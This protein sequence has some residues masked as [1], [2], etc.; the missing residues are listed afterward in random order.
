M[1]GSIPDI[2][3]GRN[4][5]PKLPR[6]ATVVLCLGLVPLMLPL[7][8]GLGATD[9]RTD[10]AIYAYAV[11]SMLES[12]DWSTPRASLTDR[13]YLSKPPL[14]FW[15]VAAGVR[16]GLIAHDERGMRTFDAVFA[17]LAFVY[18]F[19]LGARLIDP[20]AGLA[21]V[22]LLSIQPSLM[23]QH[24]LRAGGMESMLVLQFTA[25][26]YHL[27]AWARWP[28]SAWRSVHILA[29][30]AWLAFGTLGK[31][32][33]L[34][35]PV[36]LAPMV[37]LVADWRRRLW[38]DRWRWCAG[39]A[40]AAALIAPWFILQTVRHGESFWQH[41]V[42]LL[43]VRRFT[44]GLATSHVAPWHAYG[45]WLYQDLA[46][47]RALPWVTFGAGLW[48]FRVVRRRWAEGAVVLAWIVLPLL[49]LSKSTSKLHHY[50]Y[51]SLPAAAL[52]GG[53][54]LSLLAAV[55]AAL[56]RWLASGSQFAPWVE[57]RGYVA[58]AGLLLLTVWPLGEVQQVIERVDERHS[59]LR[60][61]RRCVDAL[62][63][64]VLLGEGRKGTL[65][66]M[67]R[68]A[69]VAHPYFYY[70]RHLDRWQRPRRADDSLLYFRLF[71]Q[72]HQAPTLMPADE[73]ASFLTRAAGSEIQ[74]AVHRRLARLEA[75]GL[76]SELPAPESLALPAAL[77]MRQGKVLLL[78]GPFAGCAEGALAA[79][80]RL[81][82][83]SPVQNR[84]FPAR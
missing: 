53:Y 42:G 79:G 48:A 40:L 62:G 36:T 58:C 15:I 69:K 65:F 35:V 59:P 74:A 81:A 41:F 23:F 30:A 82:T 50:L 8:L 29:L 28:G 21:A 13:P 37:L 54:A 49:L 46:A 73:Y 26:V 55:G 22:F 31:P 20:L 33:A 56:G 32:T 11:D 66:F 71:V 84:S 78:P 7:F 72:G 27:L 14:K 6:W 45:S 60:A 38:Q 68:Q 5:P 24:G 4:G 63:P 12:G 47:S 25:S 10:E 18:L 43:V 17:A 19:L 70:F 80:G 61:V 51:P 16:L 64:Q 83:Q 3:E 44:E 67:P 39:A 1:T 75:K 52:F 76:G 2:L 77:R 34:I 9:L 57:R